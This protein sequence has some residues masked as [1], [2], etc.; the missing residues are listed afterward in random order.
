VEIK[1]V[2]LIMSCITSNV[3]LMPAYTELFPLIETDVKQLKIQH[4]SRKVSKVICC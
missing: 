1:H 4:N 2:P 3:F